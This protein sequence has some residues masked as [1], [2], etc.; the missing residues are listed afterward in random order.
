MANAYLAQF[1]KLNRLQSNEGVIKM[2]R[3]R[4]DMCR[5]YS[6]AIP[7]QQAIKAIAS[8]SPLVELGAGTGY[9]SMLVKQAGAQILAYDKA[10]GV[11]HPHNSYKFSRS[12]T[13]VILGNEDILEKLDPSTNLLLCWPNYNTDFAYNSLRKFRGS[14]FVYIGEDRGGCTGNKKFFDLLD[15][16]WSIERT[17]ALP[18][19]PGIHDRLTIYTKKT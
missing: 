17:I 5:K 13:A 2:I 1:R 14:K 6:F 15:R 18:Q 8:L 9:W 4:H 10:P 11:E 16:S 12:Y 19:W 3:A 7:T